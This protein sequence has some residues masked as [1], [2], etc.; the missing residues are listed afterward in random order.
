LDVNLAGRATER[1]SC[2][3]V[4]RSRNLMRVVPLGPKLA[5]DL[6]RHWWQQKYLGILAAGAFSSRIRGQ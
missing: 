3:S 6:G 4:G 5:T 1:I 2:Y